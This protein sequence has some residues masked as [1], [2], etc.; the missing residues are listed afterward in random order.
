[1]VKALALLLTIAIVSATSEVWLP[2]VPP[3][4][5]YSTSTLNVALLY[6]VSICRPAAVATVG[7]EIVLIADSGPVAPIRYQ[8]H[9]WYIWLTPSTVQ[10][11]MPAWLS[12]STVTDEFPWVTVNAALAQGVIINVAAHAATVRNI[13]KV[14]RI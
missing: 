11:F 6:I 8:N 2:A 13:H 7:A 4:S 5:E 3:V 1:M 10:L 14:R 9:C 12:G